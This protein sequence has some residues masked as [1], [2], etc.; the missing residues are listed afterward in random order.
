MQDLILLGIVSFLIFLA[1]LINSLT[2]IP[3]VVV[4]MLLGA[5]VAN[6]GIN[7]ENEM[8]KDVAHIGFLFLMF[9]AG[10]EVDI[11]TFRTLGKNFLKKMI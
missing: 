8:M 5:F 3:I 1:P 2:K 4:E 9:L 11:K 6:I 7:I 10:I